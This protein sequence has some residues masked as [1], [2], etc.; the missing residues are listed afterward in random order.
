MDKQKADLIINEYIK[1]IYGFAVKKS[2]SYDEAEELAAD[3]VKEVYLSLRSCDDVPNPDGYVWRIS[4]HVYSRYV[5]NK[6]RHEGISIDGI[7]L[8]FYDEYSFENS[9]EDI[10]RLRREIA[11]LSQKRREIV[12]LFYYEN[13]SISFI[14]KKTS[15]SEGT[16]KWHL[17]KARNELKE[18]FN[19][20]RRIGK[21][22]LNPV[23]YTNISHGGSPASGKGPEYYI[24]DK[25]EMNICYSVYFEPKT[26][27]EI[28][29]ELGITPVYIEEKIDF[30]ER[31]GFLVPLSGGKYTTY[32][33]FR[34]ETYS[35]EAMEA[36]QKKQLEAA[37]MLAQKYVPTVREAIKDVTDVYIPGGNRELFEAAAIFYAI[38]NKCGIEDNID[39][40]KYEIRTTHGSHYYVYVNLEQTRSDPDYKPTLEKRN[41]WSCGDMTR[42]S[43]KY[44]TVASWSVDSKFC[45]RKG[46]WQNNQT[47]DYEY[48]YEVMNGTIK[49]DAVSAEK[50]ARLRSRDFLTEDG[51]PN[52]MVFK[53]TMRELDGMIPALP[54]EFKQEFA[55]YAIENAMIEAKKYPAHM[56]D[57]IVATDIGGFI[58]SITSI[59]TL[60]VLYSTKT[61]K[62]LTEEER[63]TANLIMFSDI[64]PDDNI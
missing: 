33:C 63:T 31:N 12:Y 22:G 15:L 26:K 34:P 7:S 40:S 36:R 18:G 56:Q 23:K 38:N 45:T 59:M 42:W 61:F 9:D 2:F 37:L 39:I 60:D 58:S 47:E 32:V 27:E 19:M 29:E 16:V 41:Y 43:D 64:L 5:A 13:R 14:A 1:K 62:P 4:E 54:E 57:L 6:K 20:E 55:K 25:L 46:A 51:K 49:D 30:L 8:P 52:I 53:G 3:I 10:L 24:G 35:L 48:L 28:A 50:F 44:P 11:F 21:L 17:N